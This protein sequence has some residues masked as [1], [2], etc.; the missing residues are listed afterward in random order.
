MYYIS[1]GYNCAIAYQLSTIGQNKRLNAYPFDW[2]II[3]DF[4][5]VVLL[6]ENNFDGFLSNLIN[7]GSC[8]KFS[9]I[10]N[11][12][13]IPLLPGE[14]NTS[15]PLCKV[16]NSQYN[17][18]FNH[19]FT[20]ELF[21]NRSFVIEKYNRRIKRLYDLIKSDN[22]ITF[23]RD[24]FTKNTITNE[25]LIRFFN[26]INHT[27]CNIKRKLVIIYNT[28][29][30][31]SP[32]KQ[33]DSSI[34]NNDKITIYHDTYKFGD[35]Y[36]PNVNWNLIFNDP[37]EFPIKQMASFIAPKKTN[38]R[39]KIDLDI[40]LI[41]NKYVFVSSDNDY[42]SITMTCINEY[43]YAFLNTINESL[44]HDESYQ[45][46]EFIYTN[47]IVMA[48]CMNE[49]SI[50]VTIFIDNNL[51][52]ELDISLIDIPII[53]DDNSQLN[54]VSIYIQKING[55]KKAKSTNKDT[56]ITYY[57][58]KV[59]YE[60]IT[61]D[62]VIT[63]KGGNKNKVLSNY[64]YTFRRSPYSFFQINSYS[65]PI[66]W[67]IL[68]SMIVSQQRSGSSMMKSNK[69][70]ICI[71]GQTPFIHFFANVF[72]SVIGISPTKT[73]IEDAIFNS[74]INNITNCSFIC[75]SHINALSNMNNNI[76]KTEYSIFI[77]AGRQGLTDEV[78]NYLSS[79][80]PNSIVYFISCNKISL[81]SNLTIL[82]KKTYLNYYCEF[83]NFP[84]TDTIEIIG[85]FIL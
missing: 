39:N 70:L 52:H 10:N 22:D 79:T 82:L 16:Y 20:E 71:G 1:L 6:L 76:D 25:L 78:C 14:K 13:D 80:F 50:I 4:K 84:G 55:N 19:D 7:Q 75:D 5:S 44:S 72:D 46:I 41:D 58:Q 65:I 48:N 18:E 68:Y 42:K 47:I 31:Q 73:I 40:S 12:S 8:L 61:I 21:T 60:N 74:K 29:K 30:K 63:K 37:F 34:Y 77:N 57:N 36:R 56:L 54:V 85:S 11:D 64:V 81:I 62:N 38:Y 69:T 23:I 66:I 67:N 26:C 3:K 51:L 2:L 27:S 35:W 59:L 33:I 17:I 43:L 32:F 28:Y 83:D 45:F 53:E 9:L 49:L 24:E 15:S